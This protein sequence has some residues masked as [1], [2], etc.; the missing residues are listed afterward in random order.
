MPRGE[1][2]HDAK[3]ALLTDTAQL[4]L[5]PLVLASRTTDPGERGI[6]LLQTLPNLDAKSLAL[7]LFRT[8]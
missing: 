4:L 6:P 5:P 3:A 2:D 1:T 8:I 7:E